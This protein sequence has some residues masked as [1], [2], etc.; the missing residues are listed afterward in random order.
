VSFHRSRFLLANAFYVSFLRNLFFVRKSQY[1]WYKYNSDVVSEIVLKVCLIRWNHRGGHN[2]NQ[3][4]NKIHTQIWGKNSQPVK[5]LITVTWTTYAIFGSGFWLVKQSPACCWL[6]GSHYNGLFLKGSFRL[7]FIL[8]NWFERYFLIAPWIIW[9]NEVQG[10]YFCF[11]F[12]LPLG[13]G[14]LSIPIPPPI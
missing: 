12:E 9:A 6:V 7:K 14:W 8:P 11:A 10:V 1:L 3:I 2:N 5:C 13:K 4:I